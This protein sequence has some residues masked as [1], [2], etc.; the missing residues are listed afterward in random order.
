MHFAGL[1]KLFAPGRSVEEQ[2]AARLPA[3]KVAVFDRALEL[4]TAPFNMLSVALDEAISL[5]SDGLLVL[6]QQQAAISSQV[7][8]PLSLTVTAALARMDDAARHMPDLPVV[9]S[10]NPSF[11]RGPTAQDAASWN[12]LFFH[13]LFGSRARFFLKVRTLSEMLEKIAQEFCTSADEIADATGASPE[14]SWFALECLQYDFNTCLRESEVLLK[15]FLGNLPA[16]QLP[17]FEQTL[18]IPVPAVAS[19]RRRRPVSDRV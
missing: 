7:M 19:P 3:N 14:R 12:Q 15:C 13:I 1:L 11:F 2:W 10:L 8:A 4:W 18:L 16:A 5:R 9:D 17:Q 6:A